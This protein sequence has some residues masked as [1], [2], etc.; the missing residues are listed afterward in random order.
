MKL[1]VVGATP[2]TNSWGMAASLAA[3]LGGLAGHVTLLVDGSVQSEE[4]RQSINCQTRKSLE[5]VVDDFICQ[6][7]ITAG[8][9]QRQIVQH[10]PP[11]SLGL[12]PFDV[13][14]GPAAMSAE[15]AD[16]L[17]ARRGQQFMSQLAAVCRQLRYETVVINLGT[18]NTLRAE[19]A[20]I[21]ADASLILGQSN[22]EAGTWV[23][24][25]ADVRRANLE[26]VY[27]SAARPL[28]YPN[29]E[30]VR[31]L[32]SREKPYEDAAAR[33]ALEVAETLYPS[34]SK[35]LTDAA[36][37]PIRVKQDLWRKLFG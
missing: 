10:V 24:R 37:Q 32:V 2:T 12:R 16:R 4:N 11:A 15:Y 1:L 9:V 17:A 5:W 36:G 25:L 26:T 23:A 7:T 28:S 20:M 18:V 35:R 29:P 21:V 13:L 19:A 22:E 6:R 33:L 30:F 3:V 31:S 14:A 8:D 27:W 34:I